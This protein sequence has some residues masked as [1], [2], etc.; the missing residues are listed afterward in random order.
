MDFPT[1]IKTYDGYRVRVTK[2]QF[3]ELT[4]GER[5]NRIFISEA[6]WYNWGFLR[7]G[8]Y[9]PFGAE[10]LLTRGYPRVKDV[11]GLLFQ[12]I[13]KDE[14]ITSN[15]IEER[16]YNFLMALPK[17]GFI[18][19]YKYAIQ[20]L[21]YHCDISNFYLA[22][23]LMDKKVTKKEFADDAMWNYYKSILR[24]SMGYHNY[25]LCKESLS[26]YDGSEKWWHELME[27]VAARGKSHIIDFQ[28]LQYM[29]SVED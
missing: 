28:V 3:E 6:A 7:K 25:T 12:F 29:E 2:K 18:E 1:Y 21:A 20:Y 19:G 23:M 16:I 8:D 4:K 27:K 13:I 15:A 14:W 22:T 26:S 5:A 10:V 24:G 9:D 11:L 17:D